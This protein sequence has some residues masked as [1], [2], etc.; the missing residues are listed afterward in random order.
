MSTKTLLLAVLLILV[1]LTIAIP[2]FFPAQTVMSM[3]ACAENLRSIDEAKKEWALQ[4]HGTNRIPTE[5]DLLPFIGG[6]R[7]GVGYHANRF[8]QCPSGGTYILGAIGEPPK[9]SIGG[10]GHTMP[11]N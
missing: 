6:L 8:P 5:A 9:C 3:S 11:A 4:D 2:N 7:P 10:A 1:I